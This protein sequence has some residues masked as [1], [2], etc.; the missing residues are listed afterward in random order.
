MNHFDITLDCEWIFEQV[1][2]HKELLSVIAHVY[3]C[4]WTC[5]FLFLHMSVSITLHASFSYCTFLFPLL[6]ISFDCCTCLCF[7][8]S[9]SVTGHVPFFSAHGPYWFCTCLFCYCMSFSDSSHAPYCFCTYHDYCYCMS[10]TVSVH[11]YL[12]THM[13]LSLLHMSVSISAHV[14]FFFCTCLFPILH[15]SHLVASHIS[16]F[17]QVCFCFC[18]SLSVTTCPFLFMHMSLSVTACPFLFLNMPLTVFAN[19]FLLLH[20]FSVSVHAPY[21]FCT[22]LFLLQ[23]VPFRF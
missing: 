8:T 6:H 16:L 23:H 2:I 18:T 22:C 13:F 17:A 7:Y 20:V 1:E 10:L 19:L 14:C 3:I 15:M 12:L 5:P 4:Y 21:C 11:L 9:L